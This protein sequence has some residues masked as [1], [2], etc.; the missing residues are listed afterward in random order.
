MPLRQK[1]AMWASSRVEDSILG[2]RKVCDA[3]S[4]LRSNGYQAYMG[5]VS[6]VLIYSFNKHIL[7]PSFGLNIM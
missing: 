1:P 6:V 7:G 4:S 3:Q 5:R 2:W